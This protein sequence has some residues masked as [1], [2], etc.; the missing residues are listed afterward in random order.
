MASTATRQAN[1]A[2]DVKTEAIPGDRLRTA[3]ASLTEDQEYD[4][5]EIAGRLPRDFGPNDIRQADDYAIEA[6]TGTR[7]PDAI[8]TTATVADVRRE[9][10][11]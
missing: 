8:T 9:R 7:P 3:T 11:S 2:V 4:L 1:A 6:V 5:Y 10:V